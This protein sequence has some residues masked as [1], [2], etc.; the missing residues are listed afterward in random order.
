[1]SASKDHRPPT[2]K[3][4]SRLALDRARRELL[5]SLRSSKVLRKNVEE[6]VRS[7]RTSAANG[8]PVELSAL[9]GLVRDHA[10]LLRAIQGA[11]GE[12][13][14]LGKTYALLDSALDQHKVLAYLRQLPVEDREDMVREAGLNDG[15]GLLG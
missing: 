14:Q 10:S 5:G 11:A 4:R 3:E 2:D 12:L 6:R 15:R 1:M 7:A 9:A 8:E 13:R